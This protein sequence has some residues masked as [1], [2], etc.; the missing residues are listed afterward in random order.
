MK[1]QITFDCPVCSYEVKGLD[2]GDGKGNLEINYCRH[3]Y[4][5]WSCAETHG[6]QGPLGK[7][8]DRF[9]NKKSKKTYLLLNPEE[10]KEEI[11]KLQV[12]LPQGY[13]QFKDSNKRFI[14]HGEALR[15]LHSR[16]ITN[17]LIEK[18]EIGFT[19]DGEFA[20]RVIIPSYDKDGLLN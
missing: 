7:L 5:C 4:K 19:V 9:G 15:Y 3:L 8:F 12:K 17:E 10:K 11:K 18:Y 20:Y 14:P 1:C 13:T 2:S 16:G 6:T